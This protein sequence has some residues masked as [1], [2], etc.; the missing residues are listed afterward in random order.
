M[1]EHDE[2]KQIIANSARSFTE[3]NADYVGARMPHDDYIEDFFRDLA[4]EIYEGIW[5]YIKDYD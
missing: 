5:E 3:A 1:D 4:Q 2:V